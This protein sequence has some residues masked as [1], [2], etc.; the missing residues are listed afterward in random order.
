MYVHNPAVNVA[1]FLEAEEP[2]PVGG[3]IEC[4]ALKIALVS[5]VPLP[6][7]AVSRGGA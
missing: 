1:K 5:L 3:V 6:V 4:K 7:I 2:R